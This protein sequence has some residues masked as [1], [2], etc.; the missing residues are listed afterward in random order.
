MDAGGGGGVALSTLGSSAVSQRFPERF[1]FF[2][3]LGSY[4]GYLPLS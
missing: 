1:V 2:Q 3:G 4:A